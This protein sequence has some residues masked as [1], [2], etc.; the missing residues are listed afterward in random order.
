MLPGC[1]S[2]PPKRGDTRI[3]HDRFCRSQSQVKVMLRPT[4][5]VKR[6]SG[7]QGQTFVTVKQ[8]CICG[9]GAPSLTL[10]RVCRLQLLLALARAVIL[11]SKSRGTHFTVSDSGLPILEG[12]GPVFIFPPPRKT[13]WSSY[14]TGQWV[15][16]SSPPTTRRAMVQ[17]FK[18]ASTLTIRRSVVSVLKALLSNRQ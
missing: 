1:F 11:G 10:G 16:F 18:P 17:I 6:P 2:S 4:F 7:T 5:V 9:C 3:G 14:D 15:P 13:G 12:Q 8:L